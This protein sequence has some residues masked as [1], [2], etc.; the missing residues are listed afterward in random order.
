[1]YDPLLDGEYKIDA[2]IALRM[3]YS[4]GLETLFAF[5]GAAVQAPDCVVGYLLRYENRDLNSLID[6]IRHNSRRAAGRSTDR[7]K[8]VLSRL[9]IGLCARLGGFRLGMGL[10]REP[11]VPAAPEDMR[12]MGY[13]RFGTSFFLRDFVF[14]TNR[15]NFAVERQSLNWDAR[16]YQAALTLMIDRAQPLNLYG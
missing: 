1:M 15:T 8:P 14:N 10:E 6:K 9:P 13:S 4:Q 5:L 12:V 2:A 16:K 3:A 11:G 7:F